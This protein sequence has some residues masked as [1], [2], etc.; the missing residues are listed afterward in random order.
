MNFILFWRK[1][2]RNL[3][4]NFYLKGLENEVP[5]RKFI[6]AGIFL[7]I[8]GE[9]KFQRTLKFINYENFDYGQ[10]EGPNP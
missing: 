1:K 5:F 7:S 3:N 4:R 2:Y 6:A 10:W 8:Q 9:S